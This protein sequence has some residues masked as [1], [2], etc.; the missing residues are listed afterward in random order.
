M[1][2]ADA[3]AAGR[4]EVVIYGPATWHALATDHTAS[5]AEGSTIE[6]STCSSTSPA[7]LGTGELSALRHYRIYFSSKGE[8]RSNWQLRGS[9]PP[10]VSTC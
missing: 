7:K 4:S 6:R 8:L 10:V 9:E 2:A 3:G 5:D 1:P